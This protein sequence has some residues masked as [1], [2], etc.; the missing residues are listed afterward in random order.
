MAGW[1]W[2]SGAALSNTSSTGWPAAWTN[3]RVGAI[4]GRC[5][6]VLRRLW[7]GDTE[8]RGEIWHF[9]RATSV[10]KPLQKPHPPIWVAARDPDTFAWAMGSGAHIMATPLS[11][12]HAEVAILGQ[13]FADTLAKFP[14]IRRPRFL[15]LR[16]T[17]VYAHE[18]EWRI[19]VQAS[20]E[21]GRQ[22]ENL[23]RNIGTVN[24]GFPEPAAWGQLANRDDYRPEA[25]QDSLVFGTPEQVVAKLEDYR[26]AGVDQ[27]C[28][29]ASFGLPHKIALRSLELF[30]T[31]IM[32]RFTAQPA[33]ASR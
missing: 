32:P 20:A 4:C 13:R 23:F 18:D 25:I 9:P 10:P 26:A 28:Y 21:Y 31:K 6:P 24:N 16:R 30:I 8:H 1:S 7:Q 15:M 27:F 2:V 22:F 14:G 29:G 19:P 3:A 17:C 5:C 12:P 33:D 11:R